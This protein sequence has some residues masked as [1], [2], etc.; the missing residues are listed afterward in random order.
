M[1]GHLVHMR[2]TIDDSP[3]FYVP[4]GEGWMRRT[5]RALFG[6]RLPAGH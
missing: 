5:W 2:D 3:A 1:L 4:K 6:R